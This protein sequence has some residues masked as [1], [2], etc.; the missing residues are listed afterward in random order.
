MMILKFLVYKIILI[1]KS[2]FQIAMMIK[3]ISTSNE[4]QLLIASDLAVAA[5]NAK[6]LKGYI[7]Y[8]FSFLESYLF[9]IH[10]L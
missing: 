1:K 10:F 6:D 3:K 7:R 5:F 9:Y 8:I 2:F 4:A